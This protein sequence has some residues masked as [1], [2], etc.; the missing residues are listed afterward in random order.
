MEMKQYWD[1][2]HT[3]Y[4]KADWAEQPS[5][6]SIFSLKYFP[7]SGNI[8]ELGAGQGQ[9]S[10]FFA[11]KGYR[12]TSTDFSKLALDISKER[13][14][15][16]N[17]NNINYT[18]VDMQKG[19]LDFQDSSFDIVYS[20]LSIHYFDEVTTIKLFKEIARVLKK[21]GIFAFIVNS[22][23]DPD[24]RNFEKIDEYLYRD[25]LGLQ[26]RYFTI[27]YARQRLENLFKII[28]L[29]AEGTVQDPNKPDYLIRFIGKKTKE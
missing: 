23:S 14:Q 29:D 7:T 3:F 12:V 20:H 27:D 6:F 28:I 22:M 15:K 16:A 8:L 11:Q 25:P 9:D 13:S 26:K 19:K 24:T 5:N 18:F 10:R 1:N 21:D 17:I 4:S 2:K